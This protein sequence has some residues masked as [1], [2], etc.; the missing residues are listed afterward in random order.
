MCSPL[1]DA[2][3]ASVLVPNRHSLL[4]DLAD[5]TAGLVLVLAYGGGQIA[6]LHRRGNGRLARGLGRGQIALGM[7]VGHVVSISRGA[8]GGHLLEPG[9]RASTTEMG[10]GKGTDMVGEESLVRGLR[11]LEQKGGEAAAEGREG[12]RLT[13]WRPSGDVS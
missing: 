6:V 10:T 8:E 9:K 3:T 11:G 13:G 5:Y 7:I 12:I 2:E 1:G 4:A